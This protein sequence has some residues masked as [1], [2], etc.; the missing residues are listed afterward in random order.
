MGHFM[1]Y[2][3]DGSGVTRVFDSL[4]FQNNWSQA[5]SIESLVGIVATMRELF[6]QSDITSYLEETFLHREAEHVTRQD[7]PLFLNDCGYYAC[8]QP[9]ASLITGKAARKR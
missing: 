9:L 7:K 3:N 1:T 6:E 2:A 5:F 4:H 8:S